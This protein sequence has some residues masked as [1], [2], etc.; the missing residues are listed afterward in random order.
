MELYSGTCRSDL[1]TTVV[2]LV[3]KHGADANLDA[4]ALDIDGQTP[5]HYMLYNGR[6]GAARVL[7]EHGV[8]ANSRD[9]NNATALHLASSNP[10]LV[11]ED[12][13]DVVR[14]LLQYGS[15]IHAR[16]NSGRT[17]FMIANGLS[18]FDI[19]EILSEHG[20]EVHRN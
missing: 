5:L 6:L 15:D 16:D 3:L 11:G 8:D 2:P 18:L 4:N 20:A 10:Y 7:L 19:M 9:I 12:R 17:P 1:T 14:S 13:S